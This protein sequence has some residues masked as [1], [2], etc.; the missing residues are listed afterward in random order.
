MSGSKA[1]QRRP[2]YQEAR[3]KPQHTARLQSLGLS[4][5]SRDSQSV[6]RY[7]SWTWI[8]GILLSSPARSPS[9]PVHVT[10]VCLCLSAIR[11]F[12]QSPAKLIGTSVPELQPCLLSPA[13]SYSTSPTPHMPVCKVCKALGIK[14]LSIFYLAI[15][16]EL[17]HR[18]PQKARRTAAVN[19][20]LGLH[21]LRRD[22][23][24]RLPALSPWQ[25][26][27]SEPYSSDSA[28]A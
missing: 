20:P 13:M 10:T 4:W 17:L 28:Q 27:S 12:R 9:C 2:T 25:R 23:R 8:F 6:G 22:R 19:E 5:G 15:D 11:V 21:C 7:V 1:T 3:V 16:L 24:P 18:T 14:Q 26:L